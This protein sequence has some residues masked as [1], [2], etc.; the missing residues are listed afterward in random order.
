MLSNVY[1]CS[2]CQK[3]HKN[4]KFGNGMGTR[5]NKH[6]KD[7]MLLDMF[8][9]INTSNSLGGDGEMMQVW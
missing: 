5:K 1:A 9:S 3:K 6:K 7:H 2:T 4:I 8:S